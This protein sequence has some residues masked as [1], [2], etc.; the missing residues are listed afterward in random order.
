MTKNEELKPCP[1]CGDL[2]A[3]YEWSPGCYC[4]QCTRYACNFPYAIFGCNETS[5]IKAWNEDVNKYRGEN[6]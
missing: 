1:C 2:P 4:V 5:A 3:V 6:I